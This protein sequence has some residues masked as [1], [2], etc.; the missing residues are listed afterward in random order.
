MTDTAEETPPVLKRKFRGTLEFEFEIEV[1]ANHLA[2]IQSPEWAKPYW[3]FDDEEDAVK[4]L[5]RLEH[6]HGP[7]HARDGHCGCGE[8][9]VQLDIKSEHH[10]ID[11]EVESAQASDTSNNEKSNP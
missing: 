5:A 8:S 10:Y 3:K 11:E 2:Y 6:L 7:V 9:L 1:D 4:Y